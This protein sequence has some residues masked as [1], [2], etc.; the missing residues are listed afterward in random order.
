[1][2]FTVSAEQLK[3]FHLNGYL[4]LENLISEEEV[5]HLTVALAALCT[6]SPG[7][8]AE[9]CFRSVPL[10]ASL[11]RTRGWGHITSDLLHKKPLRIA[12]DRFWSQTPEFT[13][14]LGKEDCGFVLNLRTRQG[15]FF[16]NSL[17]DALNGETQD[18]YLLLILTAK[19][20]P[21]SLNPLIV[22]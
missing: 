21:E 15:I 12:Y 14:E 20:L 6:K 4:Q 2:R 9:N 22:R 3:F 16:K 18:V 7:Y 19:H 13:R 11:A 5:D 8:T 10:I 17:P 1:M